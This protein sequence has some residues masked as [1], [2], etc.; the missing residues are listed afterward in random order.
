MFLGHD[1]L[2]ETRLRAIDGRLDDGHQ[3]FGRMPQ[4][5]VKSAQ[6]LGLE[7]GGEGRARLVQYLANAAQAQS[8]Q[9]ALG[10]LAKAERGERQGMQNAHLLT[11]GNDGAI[12]CAVTSNCPSG[13]CR[14]GYRQARDEPEG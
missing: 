11:R 9:E 10:V 1:G 6:E 13:S 5:L 4:C 14:V 12:L 7:A 3:R 8:L 2:D